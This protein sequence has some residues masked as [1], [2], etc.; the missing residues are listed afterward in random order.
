MLAARYRHSEIESQAHIAGTLAYRPPAELPGPYREPAHHAHAE[1]V[2][3][4]GGR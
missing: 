3:L 1:A 2:A 4:E